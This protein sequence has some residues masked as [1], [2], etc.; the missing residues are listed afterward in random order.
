M[1][2]SG[3]HLLA[4]L[5]FAAAAWSIAPR[6]RFIG[7]TQAQRQQNLH[8]V[9]NNN[10]FL[11]LP[12]VHSKN[13][14]SKILALVAKQLPMDWFA[15]YGYQPVLLE[16]FVQQNLFRGTCYR[17][18][19]W[20]YIGHT[21]GRGKLDRFCKHPLSVKDIFLYPLQNNFRTIL[22]SLS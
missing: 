14:A 20:V 15:R 12:W 3:Q 16:T 13:L 9:V 18:A 8:L 19:N 10:R 22:C 7:W 2:E 17:A 5:G 21:Q 1:V 4:V 11:I 6:D